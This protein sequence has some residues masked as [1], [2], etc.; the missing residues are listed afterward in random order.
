MY[1]G[2]LNSLLGTPNAC[3]NPISAPG[4]KEKK[5]SLPEP[6]ITWLNALTN[7]TSKRVEKRSVMRVFLATAKST[8]H[9]KGPRIAPKPSVASEKVACRKLAATASGLANAFGGPGLLFEPNPLG[10]IVLLWLRHSLDL[11]S[12]PTRRSSRSHRACTLSRS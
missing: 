11:H 10:P 5:E 7:C 6:N 9:R 4:W 1:R 2:T 8:F 12:F 3:G